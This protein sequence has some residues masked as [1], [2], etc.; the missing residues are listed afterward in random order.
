MR[1]SICC[2]AGIV[3]GL[4][5]SLPAHRC[6]AQGVATTTLTSRGVALDAPFTHVGSMRELPG[7]RA[8]LLDGGDHR[9]W[10]IDLA[11]RT[12]TPAAPSGLG[13]LEYD[14]PMVLFGAGATTVV[15]DFRGQKL[16]LFDKSG[17]PFESFT[18]QS[19]G[20]TR[21]SR[22]P[23]NFRGAD[24]AGRVYFEVVGIA[25]E[26]TGARAVDS[27]A[28]LR[29]DRRAPRIDTVAFIHLPPGST[30]ASGGRPGEGLSIMTGVDNAFVPHDAW[31][32]AP[33]GRVAIV[34]AQPYRIESI[35]S[36]GRRTLGPV[37]DVEK[38]AVTDAD[39]AEW[40]KRTGGGVS[41]R[42]GSGARGDAPAAQ[43]ARGGR[44]DW[45]AAKAPFPHGDVLVDPRGNVWVHRATHAG[46][47]HGRYDVFDG[48]GELIGRYVLPDRTRIVGIGATSVFA[49]H[50]TDDGEQLEL[51][52][53]PP[54]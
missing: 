26:P 45:P 42:G 8:L 13:A 21:V 43:P 16:L 33:N 29:V 6:A 15:E 20:A 10:L 41:A 27:A 46:D 40:L 22:A 18:A 39:I 54:R 47:A 2:R 14:S 32:V 36:D 12:R 48:A 30:K 28:I 44:D 38:I 4:A 53:L 17:T 37:V 24:D 51:F 34:H 11:H 19:T 50:A 1:I 9:V 52:R 23:L 25:M 31:V 7:D 35:S 3:L 5:S 49:M